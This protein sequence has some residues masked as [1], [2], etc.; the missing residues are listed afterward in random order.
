MFPKASAGTRAR[1]L[2]W[3]VS[4]GRALLY[5]TIS[6]ALTGLMEKATLLEG[7][8]YGNQAR[9]INFIGLSI[10]LFGIFVD[11]S[12]VFARYV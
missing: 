2:P 8:Y 12:L 10:L 4:G 11:L 3:H 9:T 6:A 5:M 7:K 1:A